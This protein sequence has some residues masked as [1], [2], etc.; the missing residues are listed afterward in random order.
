MSG[1]L[2]FVRANPT[3][4]GFD[5]MELRLDRMARRE[6]AKTTDRAL[7][8]GVG[9]LLSGRQPAATTAPVAEPPP[10]DPAMPAIATVQAAPSAPA[11]PAFTATVARGEAP[12]D[13]TQRINARAA[14]DPND[15]DYPE[16]IIAINNQV[17]ARTQSGAR[18][19]AEAPEGAPTAPPPAGTRAAPS[20]AAAPAPPNPYLPVLQRLVATPGAG[21]AAVNLLQRGESEATRRQ[22]ASA[23]GLA[24]GTAAD[25]RTRAAA[26]RNILYAI[27]RGE[28]DV[29]RFLGQQI[30]MEIPEEILQNSL[31]RTRFAA[32]SL[33]AQ[34]HYSGDPQQ[35]QV[36]LQN[37]I[38]TG[39]PMAA[40]RA[41]GA[42]NG[43]SAGWRAEWIQRDNTEV[44][45]FFNPQTR[46]TWVP[47]QG[48]PATGPQ[49]DQPSSLVTR[50]PRAG[51]QARPSA[52]E[53]RRR[54]LE[55]AGYTPGQAAQIAAGAYVTENQRAQAWVRLRQNIEQQVTETREPQR[56]R[57]ISAALDAARRDFDAAFP[58]MPRP[59]EAPAAGTPAPAPP[60]APPPPRP[61]SVPLGSQW[62][63]SRQQFRAPDGRLF[64]R[65]GQPVS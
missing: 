43:R 37:Y 15:P 22:M 62:S 41:A 23:R 16:Q 36:F 12:A 34:R 54:I 42:P 40:M 2:G 18:V 33:L 24:A 52:V 14:L 4:Q 25:A 13:V 60:P 59:G 3:S 48:T 10:P 8:E 58:P 20:P 17:F 32:G 47:G 61:A 30:G 44:L 56:S 28:V 21:A 49:P 7:R 9:E 26:E 27:G 31:G 35:A 19:A 55:L 64:D 51:N 45:A 63:P 53:E 46:Q 65:N 50:A 39:D 38:Q 5:A 57:A 29:A 11:R 1:A 6:D